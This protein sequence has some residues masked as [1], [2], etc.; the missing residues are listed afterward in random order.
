MFLKDVSQDL[1]KRFGNNLSDVVVVFPG[2]RA[3]LFMN[4]YLAEASDRPV[5][6]P[7]YKTIDELFTELSPYTKTDTINAICQL[8]SVYERLIPDAEPLDEFYSWGEIIL[9]D[10]DDIDKHMAPAKQIFRNVLDLQ[11]I[12]T[13]YITPEQEEALRDFF[14]NFSLEQNS[15]LKKRFLR[16]WDKMYD[17]YEQLKAKLM[18]NG[19]L[20]SGALYRDVAERIKQHQLTVNENLDKTY[21]FVGFNILDE[22]EQT[23]FMHLNHQHRALFYWDY[24]MLY[25]QDEQWEAGHFITQNLKL[26]ENAL[27]KEKFDNLKNLKDITF[28]ATST[29][30]AQSRYIPTWLGGQLTEKESETAIVLADEHSLGNVLHSIPESSPSLINVTMGFPLVDTPV[31]SFLNVLLSLYIDGFDMG[32]QT[33]RYT[34]MERV[35]RHPYY[36]YVCLKDD[37]KEG[38]IDIFVPQQL[39]CH[40]LINRLQIVLQR[41][42]AHYADKEKADVYD[43]LYIEA[44]FQCHCIL[45]RFSTLVDTTLKIMPPTLRRLLRQI[46]QTTNIPFHGEPAIGLQVMGLLETRNIDFRHLLMLNVNEGTLPKKSDDN[47]LIP[48]ILRESFGLTTIKHRISVFAYYF[49]RLISRAEHV[50]LVY[51]ESTM[52]T[53]AGE[54][55]RFMRQLMAETNLPIRYLRLMPANDH[56]EAENSNCVVKTPEMMEQLR[57]RYLNN[58]NHK[59]SPTAINTYTACPLKFYYKYIANIKTPDNIEDGITPA[60]FGTIFHDAAQL[61][62]QHLQ[63][64]SS[65]QADKPVNITAD[66]LGEALQN[67]ELRI[68]PFIDISMMLNYFSPMDDDKKNAQFD[69]LA[70]MSMQKLREYAAS[71]YQKPSNSTLLSGINHIIYSV[72]RQY[73]TQLIQYDKL[74]TPFSFAGLEKDYYYTLKL[75]SGDTILTGGRIDRLERDAEGNLVVVDYKTGGSPMPVKD[76]ESIFTHKERASGY[77]LQT[78]IYA[79]AVQQQEGGSVIPTLFYVNRAG[80]PDT[81]ERTMYLGTEKS[82]VPVADITRYRDEFVTKLTETVETIL[83]PATP[84]CATENA[85][86]CQ[87]CEFKQICG[88]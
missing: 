8:Y 76:L 22:T 39:D 51:N 44:L 43:Q 12:S 82:K 31:N 42:S 85:S 59:L 52:G 80:R 74:H 40:E 87:Y 28:V 49:Y 5:W 29:D 86:A 4:Q 57:E 18:E 34:F 79:L 2:K 70:T 75:T 37:Q 69:K 33:Y 55:S 10:F 24:D 65:Q 3:R 14:K 67:K 77:F 45:T 30:N 17:L 27:P 68:Y 36:K 38:F 71:F 88:K 72:L 61:F 16:L 13:D 7:Q 62:Y 60:L 58:T 54:M 41:I 84:F 63:N 53:N 64:T 46:W 50:T 48:Y 83:D 23:L 19:E 6:A 26:F 15:E 56:K 20:Y 25:T 11:S 47:S 1:I 9:S 35:R 73:I 32:S 21:A 78:F 81:F 66:M